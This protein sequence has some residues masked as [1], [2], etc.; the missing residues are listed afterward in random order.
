MKGE[1]ITCNSD[2]DSVFE[3][4]EFSSYESK[5]LTHCQVCFVPTE[6]INCNPPYVKGKVDSCWISFRE[7]SRPANKNELE[8]CLGMSIERWE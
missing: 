4:T 2:A 5:G 3:F 1:L 7:G 8:G 6:T